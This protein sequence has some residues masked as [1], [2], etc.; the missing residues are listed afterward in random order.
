MSYV[1]LFE[2]VPFLYFALR[3]MKFDLY[4]LTGICNIDKWES[5]KLSQSEFLSRYSFVCTVPLT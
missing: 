1:R 4:N 5:S 2:S 3:Y